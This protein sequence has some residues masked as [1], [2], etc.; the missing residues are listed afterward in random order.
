MVFYSLEFI[1]LFL[2]LSIIT[3]FF[4]GKFDTTEQ[5][6][7]QKVWLILISL[8]FYGYVNYIYTFI[9]LFSILINYAL[10][11]FIAKL[12]KNLNKKKILFI[13]GILFN[14]ILLAYY[15]YSNFFIQNIN[16]IL[17]SDLNLLNLV[18][19]LGISFFTF[20]QLAFIVDNYKN[21]MVEYNFID[22]CLS[23]VFFPKIAEGP[24]VTSNYI[25]PQ[26]NNKDKKYINYNNI[27]KGLY[28]LSIGL[29]KKIFIAD[30]IAQF[31]NVG[32]AL[33]SM[34]IW[35]AWLTS[36]SYT[37]QLYYDFSGYCDMAIGVALMFNIELPINFSSPYKSANIQEFWRN[38]H[39]TLGNF[40]TKYIYIPLGGNRK[41]KFRTYLNI[42]IIFLISGIWHGAGFT[43]IIWGILHGI[44]SIIHRAWKSSRLKLNK[45]FAIFI[46]FNCINIFWVFF[47]A[48]SISNALLILK[49]MFNFRTLSQFLTITYMDKVKLA[50]VSNNKIVLVILAIS[51][52]IAFL[53]PNTA[54]KVKTMKL[55]VVTSVETIIFITYAIFIIN[56][57]KVITSLYFNF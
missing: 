9:I 44:A 52:V 21:Q 22:Y 24:I 48:Q 29:A 36:L 14:I 17:K 7:Y 3:Y 12:N 38:W 49:S 40:L 6:I 32:F 20:Q 46:T 30:I 5:N 18:L 23:V 19:P 35:D 33:N 28:M 50:G 27:N 16:S 41:G 8:F 1:V 11:V 2:P 55:N 43:F 4:I 56:S 54:D 37:F 47:R 31:A 34:S 26:F 51:I 25:I 10:G 15:K 42:F 57:S 53:F 45:Y 39:S 13:L